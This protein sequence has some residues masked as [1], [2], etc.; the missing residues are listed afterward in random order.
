M[1]V[2]R[3]AAVRADTFLIK[4]GAILLLESREHISHIRLGAFCDHARNRKKRLVRVELRPRS[5]VLFHDLPLVEV[6]YLHRYIAKNPWNSAP[7]VEND[8]KERVSL[9]LKIGAYQLVLKLGLV[10]HLVHVQ[11]LALVRIAGDE[12][13]VFSPEEGRI[14]D[15]DDRTRAMHFLRHLDRVEELRHRARAS[16]YVGTQ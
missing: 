6:T 1:R 11:V 12:S 15:K 4:V 2:D 14:N 16:V 8:R 5:E 9:L 13:A 3:L 7:S 10:A